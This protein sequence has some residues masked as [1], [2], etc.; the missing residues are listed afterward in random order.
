MKEYLSCHNLI[1]DKL[2]KLTD[3]YNDGMEEDSLLN[4]KFEKLF[5][6]KE[7]KQQIVILKEICKDV[8]DDYKVTDRGPKFNL[9]VEILVDIYLNCSP[10]HTAKRLLA[11]TFQ[12]FKDDLKTVVCEKMIEEVTVK[13]TAEV[14]DIQTGRETVNMIYCLMENFKL[15]EKCLSEI[16]LPVLQ[17]LSSALENFVAAKSCDLSPVEDNEV[18]HHCLATI[19]ASGKLLQKCS[20]GTGAG[21]TEIDIQGDIQFISRAFFNN[22]ML[23][24]K[25]DNFLLD[26]KTS[27][28]M[29]LT[30]LLK[31]TMGQKVTELILD[32]VFGEDIA[33][34]AHIP[35]WMLQTTFCKSELSQLS[36]TSCLCLWFGILAQL[37]VSDLL[38]HSSN[39][40]SLLTDVMLMRI[41]SVGNCDPGGKLQMARTV[42]MWTTRALACLK[43]DSCDPRVASRLTGSEALLQ[44]LL[45]F[46][47][48][49]W[50]DTT[51]VIRF[52][53]KDIFESVI[54]IHKT[55]VNTKASEDQ[56]LLDLTR[57]LLFEVS[58]SGKGKYGTLRT[59]AENL[60]VST[61]LQFKPELAQDILNNLKEQTVAC[62]ASDLYDKLLTEHLKELSQTGNR[63]CWQKTWVWPVLEC[64]MGNNTQQRTFVIEYIL[65]KLLKTGKDTLQYMI[66]SICSNNHSV[67]DD[68]L[69]ALI[70][71]LRR[72]RV[73][74]LLDNSESKSSDCLYGV[75]KIE[76]VKQ[77]LSHTDDQARLDAFA[78]L[79]ENHKTSEPID[80]SEFRLLKYFIQWNMKN[81]SPSFR[82]HMVA[83][84]KKLFIR[85]KE[86][87][88]ALCRKL[89]SRNKS[90]DVNRALMFYKDFGAWLFQFLLHSLY[91]GSAFA[92]RTT[93]LSILSVMVNL[94]HP[95]NKGGYVLWSEWKGCH[96][97][98]LM[99]CL[100]DTFEDNK[101]EAYNILK[102]CF[103][104]GLYLKNMIRMSNDEL[105]DISMELAGSNRP[106][107]CTTGAF[108]LRILLLQ[109]NI[110]DFLLNPE[111][112]L[113]K[114]LT[115]SAL[116]QW[117]D[118]L[119]GTQN[120]KAA[121]QKISQQASSN[122]SSRG[123]L[124]LVWILLLY[125]EDQ[126]KIAK[127]GLFIAAATKPMYPTLHC[128]R[129]ILFGVNL[130]KLSKEEMLLW[131]PVM[132]KLLECCLVISDIVSPVVQNSS[133]EGNVPEEA[134]KGV[135][136]IFAS[137]GKMNTSEAERLVETVTLMPEYLVV[138]CWRNV[139]E[140]S[141][142]LGQLTFEAPITT[143]DTSVIGL[144]TV[145]QNEI[146]GEYF[147]KQLMESIHRGAFELA[148]AGFVKQ[149]EMLWRC[150]IKALH[151]LP[152]LWLEQVMADIKNDDETNKL[153]ATRR[154]AGIPFFVQTL[155]CT[156]PQS[157]GRPCFKWTMTE[158]LLL[159][160]KEDRLCGTLSNSKVHALNILRALYKD[161]RLG[162]VV[163]S[164]VADGLRAAILGFQSPFWAVR[165]SSTLLLSTMMTRIFGVKRSKDESNLSKKNCQTGR[166]FF[167]QYPSLYPF[168]LNLLEVATR[169]IS[170]TAQL[171]LHP[172]LYPVLMILGRLF[173]SPL[174]GADTSLNLAAFI[175]YVIKCSS[176]PVLKTRLMAT[177]ALHPLVQKGQ[178]TSVMSQLINL[179]PASQEAAKHSHVH[180]ALVQILNMMDMILAL[181]EGINCSECG[182]SM[183]KDKM[184]LLTRKN[185]CYMTKEAAF[186]V[187]E[188]VLKV[189][190]QFPNEQ[191]SDIS[192]V[193]SK[194]LQGALNEEFLS[195]TYNR[196]DLCS[197]PVFVEYITRIA[198]MDLQLS[199]RHSTS[200]SDMQTKVQALLAS[201]IYEVRLVILDTLITLYNE[202][203]TYMKASPQ[204]EN[205]STDIAN[206]EQVTSSAA[207]E[208]VMS[209]AATEFVMSLL[210]YLLNM[211]LYKE[212]HFECQIQLFKALD[213]HPL[214]LKK[215][216]KDLGVQQNS[217]QVLKQC[218]AVIESSW[219]DEV[220]A[221][222][223]RFTRWLISDVLDHWTDDCVEMVHSWMMILR[224]SVETEKITD[225]Q[226]S[227]AM[228]IQ[229]NANCLLKNCQSTL[230]VQPSLTLDYLV[231][232]FVGTHAVTKGANCLLTL[233]SW[234]IDNDSSSEGAERLFDK[235]EMNV[236]REDVLF[237]QVILKYCLTLILSTQLRDS[238]TED[239]DVTPLTPNVE[240]SSDVKGTSG[241][242]KVLSQLHLVVDENFSL[243]NTVLPVTKT[244]MSEVLEMIGSFLKKF[245]CS[246]GSEKAKPFLKTNAFQDSL[247][248]Q[249]K[250]KVLG[251]IYKILCDI[252]EHS[253]SDQEVCVMSMESKSETAN[254]THPN[255]F[256]SN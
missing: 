46:I 185:P 78:L 227:V 117:E 97:Q 167:N 59:L 121:L 149:C 7:I 56:F 187:S 52:T 245:S 226:L 251:F 239:E 8:Q 129:Y 224:D 90:L 6:M 25:S 96:I 161:S 241:V 193:I 208:R 39:N 81:Q 181:P 219:R 127:N 64:M 20:G 18:M 51:D 231:R 250:C 252:T 47:W 57:S 244:N 141:L 38:H 133:P 73:M 202:N 150:N 82:Q 156:E 201:E 180:G 76:L 122:D 216:W 36:S 116:T 160:L 32:V 220:K 190:R 170:D 1:R 174:E 99:E 54:K 62:Y 158:L 118:L 234:M 69:G 35:D 186:E 175:P 44:R 138:C 31:L 172:G 105:L 171:H 102:Q 66:S 111:E 209:S 179:V 247:L 95:A 53:A 5:E 98:T 9:P 29:C 136:S 204:P 128:I 70:M 13:V 4:R 196:K 94:F 178:L 114:Y 188:K 137:E 24:L 92:R 77:A 107:D 89:H 240:G 109:P 123:T 74:G 30:L 40:K 254:F 58:W 198:K 153:C 176:S 75:V 246:A 184:W 124:L 144:L 134:I 162:E 215:D 120:L 79:C 199:L 100:T 256:V 23:I 152:K 248:E 189:M 67:S 148:C 223:I 21:N 159:A 55:A 140:V 143:P 213:L 230:A 163:T 14:K 205:N 26:C 108:L 41:L 139:K 3:I 154:S 61:L 192:T 17:Y 232:S 253:F 194:K 60:K 229:H 221:A 195:G 147:K 142:L 34:K 42:H 255:C 63:E 203:K 249:Y 146:I 233:I 11:S 10:K 85:F 125:L 169:N 132:G 48:T 210:P 91:P 104:Q 106:Q 242:E 12:N 135:E 173:Q 182:L 131:Q 101:M 206:M 103:N 228:V 222:V 15:G 155:V 217:T 88:G 22:I 37:D 45:D 157:T 119:N 80:Q 177:K 87:E 71:C 83:H 33:S 65:P 218:L 166:Q 50:E 110:Q 130:R 112:T 28:S 86:S 165:N 236:F 212:Q 145:Q 200:S 43:S 49:I 214:L 19:Q 191:I 115:P 225:L 207:T 235:S 113:P 168:L 72:A 238:N 243:S 16:F 211:A 151:Q 183:W 2:M 93:A 126:L 164:F 27:G 84:V 237:Y 68:Q 197:V